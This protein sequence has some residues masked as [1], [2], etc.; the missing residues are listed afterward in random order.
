MALTGWK[1]NPAGV[2][3]MLAQPGVAALVRQ[4]SQ[5]GLEYAQAAAPVRSGR[6]RDS[7]FVLEPRLDEGGTWV[8]GFGTNSH[9]WHFVEYGSPHSAPLRVLTN[10]AMSV[11]G[12]T[13]VPR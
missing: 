10:A 2:H 12:G 3:A 6:Y 9:I 7:L 4:V 11:T 1:A 13:A 8:G 5:R